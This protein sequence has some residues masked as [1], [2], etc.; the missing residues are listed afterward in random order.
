MYKYNIN[1]IFLII[2]Y[3]ILSKRTN[4]LTVIL[5][6]MSHSREVELLHFLGFSTD[7]IKIFKQNKR[8]CVSWKKPRILPDYEKFSIQN[9][10]E[11]V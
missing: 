6:H 10:L 9:N 7:H 11:T 8:A 4:K 2:T 1:P 5:D 3:T